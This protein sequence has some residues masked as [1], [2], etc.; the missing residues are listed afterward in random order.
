M[1]KDLGVRDHEGAR[2]KFEAGMRENAEQAAEIAELQKQVGK[3]GAENA[4]LRKQ[5]QAALK[6]NRGWF[7]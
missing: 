3:L 1:F 5:L 4:A 6:R 2:L 7:K